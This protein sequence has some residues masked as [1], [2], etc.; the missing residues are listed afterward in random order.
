MRKALALIVSVMLIIVCIPGCSK[1]IKDIDKPE[2]PVTLEQVNTDG[3]YVARAYLES[4]FSDNRELFVKCYIDGF[5]ERLEKKSGK[6]IFEEY[7]KSLTSI[8]AKVVGTAFNDYREFT[9]E[10]GFDPASMR[11]GISFLTGLDYSA[12]EQI[13]LQ[14]ITVFFKNGEETASSDFYYVVYKTG[15]KW[16]ML[17]SY[18]GQMRF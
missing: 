7:K 16:Y 9:V 10:N 5:V 6:N 3:R 13:Q 2:A 15:G 12:I 14:K 17:E 4:I 18:D 8:N 11:S 1:K